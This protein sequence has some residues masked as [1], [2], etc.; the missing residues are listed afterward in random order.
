MSHSIQCRGFQAAGIAA[1]IKKNQLPDLGLIYTPQPAVAAGVFTR[2]KVQA[3][4]VQVTRRHISNG[5]ACAVIVNSGNA[6]CCTGDQG[7]K[8]AQSMIRMTASG[9]GI[10]PEQVMVASTGVIGAYLPMDKIEAAG[11]RL[12]S[13]L[14]PDGFQDFSQ[15]IMTTDKVPKLIRREGEMDGRRF[16]LMAVAKGAGMIRPDMATMLCFVCTDADI[17]HP[18]LQQALNEAVDRSLNCITIDGDTSTN[19]MVLA[20]ANGQSG[21]KIET[22]EQR[23][24]FQELLGDL[25]EEMA[26]RL[27]QDGEGVTKVV[28]IRIEGAASDKDAYRVADTV[29]HSPLVKTAFF[30][31][32]A[33]WGR[34]IAAVGRSGAWMDPTQIDIYFDDVP[35]VQKGCGCGPE[36]EARATAV[37][38]KPTFSVVIAL[39]QGTGSARILTSDFSVE[40]VK[41][42][43]DYRS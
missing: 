14:R 41:I 28:D 20:M 16:T 40:Y 29:A 10:S 31:E 9:L 38:Q 27:V 24:S 6:N 13:A 5:R 23:E 22:A 12:M 33:N 18:V 19:D 36:A 4:P 21:V 8:D 15:A 42:N 11:P 39:H 26:R 17:S 37:L 7:E 25:L 32:D 34:I 30:G 43:A 2:N 3:A 1:G 35:M